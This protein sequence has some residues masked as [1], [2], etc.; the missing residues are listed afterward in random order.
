MDVGEGRQRLGNGGDVMTKS[1][2]QHF[3]NIL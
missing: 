2:Y 1:F 3:A